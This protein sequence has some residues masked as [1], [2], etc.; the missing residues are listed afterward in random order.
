MI[1][2]FENFYYFETFQSINLIIIFSAAKISDKK[3]GDELSPCNKLHT[4][5]GE[6]I[7]YNIFNNLYILVAVN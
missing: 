5:F 4:I 1:K 7:F 3:G 6:N 2:L